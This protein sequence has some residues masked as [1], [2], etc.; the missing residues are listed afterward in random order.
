MFQVFA[1][2]QLDHQIRHP[3]INKPQA[4]HK[5]IQKSR[6]R[7]KAVDIDSS[8]DKDKTHSAW[9][10]TADLNK[11]DACP[12]IQSNNGELKLR[13][14]DFPDVTWACCPCGRGKKLAGP[15]R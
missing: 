15:C 2:L 12:H 10:Q 5:R 11:I 13:M 14:L 1:S 4:L 6:D 8:S 3:K 7:R 9:K